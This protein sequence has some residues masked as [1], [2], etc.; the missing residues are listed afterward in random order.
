M[1]GNTQRSSWKRFN[2]NFWE[3]R[4]DLFHSWPFKIFYFLTMYMY[5][6]DKNE[7]KLRCNVCCPNQKTWENIMKQMKNANNLTILKNHYS[8]FSDFPYNLIVC[9][10]EE[11][12]VIQYYGFLILHI[13]SN[14]I[15]WECS[16]VIKIV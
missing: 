16:Q 8:H 12:M 4:L 11:L 7:K 9:I 3:A 1:E 6:F 14:I 13:S 2:S 10:F 15:S 5:Y